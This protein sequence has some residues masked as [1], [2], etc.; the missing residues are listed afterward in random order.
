MKRHRVNWIAVV[1]QV[2]FVIVTC[3]LGAIVA[4]WGS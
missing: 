3:I 4:S 1:V 2:L